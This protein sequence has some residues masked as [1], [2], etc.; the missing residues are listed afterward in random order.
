MMATTT[1]KTFHFYLRLRK[2]MKDG[3]ARFYTIQGPA[4]SYVPPQ[5]YPHSYAYH[6]SIQNNQNVC[7]LTD[8][9]I[10]EMLGSKF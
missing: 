3:Q 10:K 4:L 9:W 2:V 7:P 8:K 1:E 6:S 5:K